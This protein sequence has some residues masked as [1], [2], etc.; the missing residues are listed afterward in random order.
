MADVDALFQDFARSF[1][2]DRATDPRPYLE[3]VDGVDREELRLRIEA[4]LERAPRREWDREA[5]A[6]SMAERAVAAASPEIDAPAVEDAKGW[7]EL[8]PALRDAARLKRTEV[9]ARLASALGFPDSERRVEEYLHR[10]EMGALP[11]AGVSNRVL[12]ALG[13]ILGASAETLRRAGEAGEA[14]GA[15]GGEVFARR[16]A[17][18]D[19]MASPGVESHDVAY[20]SVA[21]ASKREGRPLDELDRLFTEG[22]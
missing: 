2:D 8:L 20:E 16:G 6:G 4:F 5:F 14:G 11:A 18:S 19:G 1:E 3:R 13:S 10:M 17:P 9:A 21:D 22:D 12:E 7:P 15:V